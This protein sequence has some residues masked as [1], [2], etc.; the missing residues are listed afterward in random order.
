MSLIASASKMSG[1]G[2]DGEEV[3][4]GVEEGFDPGQVPVCELPFGESV[5]AAVFGAVGEVGA[6]GADGGGDIS[7]SV[8]FPCGL[9]GEDD[10]AVH[11]FRGGGAVDAAAGEAVV[12]RL[13]AGGG[14]E[15][16]A[17]VEEA[18]VDVADGVGVVVQ[19]A[20]GPEVVGEVVAV[21]LEVGRQ[22]A[23]GDER[24]GGEGERHGVSLGSARPRGLGPVEHRAGAVLG[25]ADNDRHRLV[26]LGG[27]DQCRCGV[28]ARHDRRWHRIPISECEPS[29]PR[30]R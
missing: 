4:F 30:V 24:G 19:D 26:F 15:V 5:A 13:V 3:G 16:G 23:V 11:E 1:N 12:G 6:V 29:G 28:P 17:G 14:G 9:A 27:A 22:P 20:R 18:P 7:G 21:R 8:R 10:A 2:L 25:A